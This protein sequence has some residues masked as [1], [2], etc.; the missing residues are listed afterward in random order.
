MTRNQPYILSNKT[1]QIFFCNFYNNMRK[2]EKEKKQS[3]VLGWSL[4]APVSKNNSHSYE[5][6]TRLFARQLLDTRNGTC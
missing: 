3:P 1:S 5:L 4:Q 6:P 2:A